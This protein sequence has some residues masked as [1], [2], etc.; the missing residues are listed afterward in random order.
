MLSIRITLNNGSKFFINESTKGISLV[1]NIKDSFMYQSVLEFKVT[2]KL[3]NVVKQSNPFDFDYEFKKQDV[4]RF[5]SVNTHTI[6]I[7]SFGISKNEIE[8]N[9]Q[10]YFDSTSFR[11]LM[12][13]GI[14]CSHWLYDKNEEWVAFPKEED[15]KRITKIR[16]YNRGLMNTITSYNNWINRY[17]KNS[18]HR[19][20]E[21]HHKLMLNPIIQQ[22]CL[23]GFNSCYEF[24]V[25]EK[26]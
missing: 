24:L 3:M 19:C 4:L 13:C 15:Y 21:S 16:Y 5:E 7:E 17:D 23:L 20:F 2:W 8:I 11:R 12:E 26:I 22:I 18:W 14:T 6:D 1:D 25:Y 10:L 9:K